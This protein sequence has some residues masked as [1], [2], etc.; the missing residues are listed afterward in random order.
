MRESAAAFKA[1]NFH[2]PGF[3]V[4]QQV[5][6]TTVMAGKRGAITYIAHDLPHGGEV[7]IIS[8]DAQTLAAVHAFTAFQ[9]QEHH[10]SGTGTPMALGHPHSGH[11][12]Q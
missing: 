6:G 4:A 2:I 12:H 10:V 9:R 3:I 7:R 5:P 8:R 11:S 1:G